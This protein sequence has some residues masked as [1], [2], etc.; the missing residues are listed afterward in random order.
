MKGDLWSFNPPIEKR[1]N[2][3]PSLLIRA[4]GV[5]GGGCTVAVLQ[6]W[7]G[8]AIKY[9]DRVNLTQE[10]ARKQC[11]AAVSQAVPEIAPEMVERELLELDGRLQELLRS[12]AQAEPEPAADPDR[13]EPAMS[14]IATSGRHLHEISGD[15]VSVISTL[16][17]TEPVLFFKGTV[18][19]RLR[20]NSAVE[21]ERLT[22]PGLRGI[23]DRAA[24]FVDMSGIPKPARPP[25]DVIEDLLALPD[26]PLPR[27]EG[28]RSFPVFLPGG[29]LLATPG[30]DAETGWY[31]APS[32]LGGLR[33]DL[34]AEE[35][36][37]VLKSDL[38]GDFPFVEDCD[39]AHG[40]AMLLEP[41]V[42]PMIVGATPLYLIEAPTRGTGKGLLADVSVL[43][44]LGAPASIMPVTGS[45]EMEK[46]LT[47]TF[48]GGDPIILFD[49]VTWLGPA[50]LAAAITGTVWR[51]RVLGVSKM[52]SLPICVTWIATA[53]NCELTDEAARRA[54]RIRLDV[55]MERPEE[56]T[57]FRHPDLPGWVKENR[58]RLVSACLSLI[59][60]WIDHGQPGFNGT[61]GSFEAWA[62]SM[63]GILDVAGVAGFLTGR[64]KFYEQADRETEEWKALCSAWGEAYKGLRVTAADVLGLARQHDLLMELWAG[65]SDLAARQRFGKALVSRRDRRFGD[66][67]LQLAGTDGHTKTTCFSLVNLKAGPDPNPANT[68]NSANVPK[69]DAANG[70][71]LLLAS[72]E[73]PQAP[74]ETPHPGSASQ[75]RPAGFAEF[76]GFVPPVAASPADT[77]FSCRQRRPDALGEETPPEEPGSSDEPA[78]LAAAFDARQRTDWEAF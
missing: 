42:R 75:A 4:A 54:V 47:A 35:A 38:L 51:G 62:Q 37:H 58:G 55:G 15:C 60:R 65:R 44:A 67:V 66:Y 41:F 69:Q 33:T 28:I 72:D 36:L 63:G 8:E 39:R 74:D 34:S 46:R 68:A 24:R 61:L 43:P 3:G 70:G 27:L 77:K 49:N 52:V 5:D 53:N 21:A 59:Q 29:R 22:V 23:L 57:G 50:C 64:E 32:D 78:A 19:V 2:D 12:A 9:T 11:A 48:L 40:L 14:V 10:K 13:Q 6:V 20:R 45:E 1:L 18:P 26:L 73:T 31:L 76:A 16:N 17:Q 25:K 7:L 30:Y 56:R 71:V